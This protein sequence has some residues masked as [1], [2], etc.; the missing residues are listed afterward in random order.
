MFTTIY[1]SLMLTNTESYT[2]PWSPFWKY[3]PDY[4]VFSDSCDSE[5]TDPFDPDMWIDS[6]WIQPLYALHVL[7]DHIIH[8]L[9]K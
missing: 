6:T 2:N 4:P 1:D 7:P 9:R 5:K 3:K 8:P